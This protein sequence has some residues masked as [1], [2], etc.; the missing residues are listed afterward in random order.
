MAELHQ[1][2]ADDSRQLVHRLTRHQLHKIADE[3]DLQYPS[4]AAKSVMIKL[5]EAH[6]VDIT[7][8]Q[9]VRWITVGGMDSNGQPIQQS[10][11]VAEQSASARNN[12]DAHAVLDARMS[13]KE[14]KEEKFKEARLD[15]L[16]RENAELRLKNEQFET[17]EKRLAALEKP[18]KPSGSPADPYWALYRKAREMGLDVDRAMKLGQIEKMIAKAEQS[19]G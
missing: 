3:K 14:E 19:D 11:P 7:Q 8:S 13:A 4:G 5:F 10:Y 2:V 1:F 16:E 6:N 12:V 9:V 17:M 18:E 15:V